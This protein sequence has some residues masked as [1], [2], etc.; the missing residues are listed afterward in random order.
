MST[1]KIKCITVVTNEGVASYIAGSLNIASIEAAFYRVCG[2]P[3]PC[4]HVKNTEGDILTE[5]RCIHN[6]EIN[7]ESDT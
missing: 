6:V 3:Y 4:F 7:Y 1:P 2:D 5:I